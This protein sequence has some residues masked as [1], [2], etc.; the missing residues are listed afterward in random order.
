VYARETSARIHLESCR[1]RD[2]AERSNSDEA[3]A[4][5]VF[6]R[7]R[8]LMIV[9]TSARLCARCRRRRQSA[10]HSP[11]SCRSAGDRTSG[12][13]VSVPAVRRVHRNPFSAEL[14]R[15]AARLLNAAAPPV[16]VRV[17]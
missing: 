16:P 4:D 11:S 6:A 9:I 8:L 2:D 10:S 13:S 1:P 7:V 17:D 15:R 12:A 5:L 14:P 3:R